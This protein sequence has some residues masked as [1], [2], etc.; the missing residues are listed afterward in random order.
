MW[1]RFW[2][3]Y[4]EPKT[5][6][7]ANRGQIYRLIGIRFFKYYL[8]TSGDV[9]SRLRGHR[10]L[11][12]REGRDHGLRAYERRTRIYEGRHIFGGLSMLAIS[13]WAIAA[14]DRGNWA[15]L[16]AANLFLNGYPILLQRYNRVRVFAA[17]KH[18]ERA[19]SATSER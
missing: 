12:L 19:G 3:W 7:E 5:F 2:D 15:A 4:F 8:P 18:L 9:V 13:W 14:R 6:E 10:H 17:L 16:L 11:D 1:R